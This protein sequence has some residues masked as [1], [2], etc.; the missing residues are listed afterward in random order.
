MGTT[1]GLADGG[2]EALVSLLPA[3]SRQRARSVLAA[4]VAFADG[5][6]V[7]ARPGHLL[8]ADIVE[9]FCVRG[10]AGR[11]S[12]TRGT[13][14]SVLD[15]LGEAAG[16]APAARRTP[17]SGA[18]APSPYSLGERA[19]LVAVAH[20][21]RTRAKRSSALAVL[22][23]GIGAGLRAGEIVACAGPD[24]SRRSGEVVVT[25]G[26]R[27]PRVVPVSAPWGPLAEDL[28]AR[29]GEGAVFRPG[30]T[31]RAYKNALND[32]CA[33]L[34]A[35]PSAPALSSRRAR[36]SFLC[37]H[38]ARGTPVGLLIE[39]AGLDEVESLARYARHVPSAPQGKAALRAVLAAEA[40]R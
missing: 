1:S 16:L 40:L 18:A 11:R 5:H 30:L 36:S 38:L 23:L 17:F 39:I 32:F 24:V 13:Y 27:R 7:A 9:A 12:S 28:A 29:A 26:G 14:R 2:A 34:V 8:D 22:A 10:L 25:V 31:E 4:L 19:E 21:Q 33:H 20:A 37:D 15:R 6:G 35:D 3:P